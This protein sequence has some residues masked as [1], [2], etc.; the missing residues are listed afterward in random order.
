MNGHHAHFVARDLHVAL[1]FG[2][3]VAQPGQKPLQRRGLAPFVLQREIEKLVE[4]V[5]GFGSEPRQEASPSLAFAK[6]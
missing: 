4:R 2:A 3:R 1:H 6:E 5:A